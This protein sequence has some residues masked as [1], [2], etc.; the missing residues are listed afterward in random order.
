MDVI[1]VDPHHP[2]RGVSVAGGQMKDQATQSSGQMT[3]H[4]Q[5]SGEGGVGCLDKT[6]S[7]SGEHVGVTPDLI[8]LGQ[9]RGRGQE[10]ACQDSPGDT[11]VEKTARLVAACTAAATAAVLKA[12]QVSTCMCMLHACY[13]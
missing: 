13:M 12:Q 9:S 10:G 1:D 3:H 8:K 4:D 7:V 5:D 2:Y 6:T 11:S